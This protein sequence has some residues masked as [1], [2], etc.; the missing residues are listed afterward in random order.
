[1]VGN[2]LPLLRALD[3]SYVGSNIGKTGVKQYAMGAQ[4]S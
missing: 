1:M 4:D 3:I 2:G